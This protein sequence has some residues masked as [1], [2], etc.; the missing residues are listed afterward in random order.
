ME[1]CGGR[2]GSARLEAAVLYDVSGFGQDRSSVSQVG[3]LPAVG[4]V[5]QD[6]ITIEGTIGR[7][8]AWRYLFDADYDQLR[9][10]LKTAFTLNDLAVSIPLGPCMGHATSKCRS[11]SAMAC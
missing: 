4:Q 7:G 3:A 2:F 1:L 8:H 11:T 9:A 10:N 5:R 6:R